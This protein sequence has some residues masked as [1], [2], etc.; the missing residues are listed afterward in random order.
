[1]AANLKATSIPKLQVVEDQI[2]RRRR[3]TLLVKC[4]AI[5]EVKTT[6]NLFASRSSACTNYSSKRT[7]RAG[8]VCEPTN[9]A[10]LDPAAVCGA[11]EHWRAVRHTGTGV[12]CNGEDLRRL[13]TR[14]V[15]RFG[16]AS[17]WRVTARPARLCGRGRES[18]RRR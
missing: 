7:V 4:G 13:P 12:A 18:A 2:G 15:A 3:M 16:S 9:A 10:R 17:A 11:R 1:H 14:L 8:G 6:A 5:G